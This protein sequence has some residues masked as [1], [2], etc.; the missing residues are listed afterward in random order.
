MDIEIQ[1]DTP[2]FMEMGVQAN[3]DDII[4]ETMRERR[5]P[6]PKPGTVPTVD[7]TSPEYIEKMKKYRREYYSKKYHEDPDYKEYSLRKRKENL[8]KKKDAVLNNVLQHNPNEVANV[9][10]QL[11]LDNDSINQVVPMST[12]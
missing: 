4:K 2:T 6:G 5:K 1:T 12:E 8:Q 9:M 11:D 3:P 10:N 7:K